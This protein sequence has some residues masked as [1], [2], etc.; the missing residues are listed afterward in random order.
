MRGEWRARARA[1][2]SAR[3]K[4]R[5]RAVCA[6]AQTLQANIRVNERKKHASLCEQRPKFKVT[7]FLLSAAVFERRV[8]ARNS[9]FFDLYRLFGVRSLWL[10]T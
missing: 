1:H 3:D 10:R 6:R 9:K 5:E 7:I 4:T 2:I 8:R